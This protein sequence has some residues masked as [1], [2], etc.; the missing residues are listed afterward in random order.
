[1]DTL[2]I[3][4]VDTEAFLSALSTPLRREVASILAT[5]RVS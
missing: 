4:F 2:R 1:M 3:N 5:E